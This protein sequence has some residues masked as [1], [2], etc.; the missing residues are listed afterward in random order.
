MEVPPY[1]SLTFMAGFSSP[2]PSCDAKARRKPL[3]LGPSLLPTTS[4]FPGL[5]LRLHQHC[6]STQTRGSINLTII[7]E[8]PPR[9]PGVQN[10]HLPTIKSTTVAC[11]S[12][13]ERDFLV[14]SGE[15]LTIVI[16]RPAFPSPVFLLS[17]RQSPLVS[18]CKPL[19]FFQWQFEEV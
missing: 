8:Q 4:Y 3:P 10:L 19:D 17:R 5:V 13:T 16:S 11:G 1:I 6:L 7:H 9:W 15:A 2:E 12:H 18:P 14:K